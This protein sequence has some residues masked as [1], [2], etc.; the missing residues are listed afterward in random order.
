MTDTV[1]NNTND[2][3]IIATTYKGKGRIHSS[4]NFLIKN[5]LSN[6]SS[7]ALFQVA[8][9]LI[10]VLKI[11]ITIKLNGVEKS[12]IYLKYLLN[13]VLFTGLSIILF[14]IIDIIFN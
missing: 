7:L 5:S 14:F 2:Q 3:D 13:I 11:F 12:T 4:L 6:L 9:N 1:D 10:E 8:S